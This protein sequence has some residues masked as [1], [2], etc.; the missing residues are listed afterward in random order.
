MSYN[1]RYHPAFAWG[2]WIV[3]VCFVI[4][5]IAAVTDVVPLA[6]QPRFITLLVATMVVGGAIAMTGFL[7]SYDRNAYPVMIAIWLIVVILC[8]ILYLTP[9]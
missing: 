3:F 8:V 9:R 7:K 5:A 6:L 1:R 2:Y 4:M